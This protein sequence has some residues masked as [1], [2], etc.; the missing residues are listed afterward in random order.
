MITRKTR[1][2]ILAVLSLTAVSFWISR[3]QETDMPEP[4]AGLD[5]KLNYVLRDFEL[6]F[7]DENGRPTM[8][9]QAPVLRN[10]PELELGTIE[11]PIVILNQADLVWNLRSETA[12]VTADKEH[13]QLSG[14]VHVKR[15][16]PAT[17][18]WV[19]LRTREVHIEVTPQTAVT[20][21]PVS[22]FDGY[23]QLDAIGLELDMKANTFKLKQQV[24]ATYAVN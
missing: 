11:Y 17:G 15:N 18:H 3:S 13:V 6:Q 16:E 10:D 21:Q 12:T 2:G 5:P 14:Q 8:N 20:D 22:M 1:N 4:V 7:Y 23:N 9:M 19:E 24:K